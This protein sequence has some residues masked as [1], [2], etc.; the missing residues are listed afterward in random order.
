[1]KKGYQMVRFSND[2]DILKYEPILFTELHLANQ[3]LVAGT[4]G[5]LTGTTLTASGSNF[6][7]AQVQPGQVI[8]MQ[9]AD[10]ALDGAYEVVSVDSATQLTVSVVRSDEID[11]PV[12]PPAASDISYRISTFDQQ[13]SEVAFQL[14]EFFGIKPGNPVSDVE[15]E[16]IFDAEVLRRASVFAVIST[17]YAMHAS[18]AKDEN[19]WNKSLH[20]QRLFEKAKQRCR[21]SIDL[22]SDGVADVTRIGSSIRLVRD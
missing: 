12:S 8:Y 17:I 16:D 3:I 10:G 5:T 20:Y 11:I 2:V 19:F 21:L 15:A 7:S 9:S 4:G 22:G 1:M 6:L 13:A 18:K 14:T